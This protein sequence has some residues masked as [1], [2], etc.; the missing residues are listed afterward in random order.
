MISYRGNPLSYYL[1]VVQARQQ[2]ELL[3]FIFVIKVRFA[4]FHSISKCELQKAV[5]DNNKFHRLT[6]YSDQLKTCQ[7]EYG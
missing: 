3:R 1:I 5:V 2:G 6:D 7:A 4:E